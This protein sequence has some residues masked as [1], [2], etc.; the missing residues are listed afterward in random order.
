MIHQPMEPQ[1]NLPRE[2]EDRFGVTL[3][4]E[5]RQSLGPWQV[6]RLD[7]ISQ[8]GFKVAWLPGVNPDRPLRIRIPGLSML[9]AEI[10]WM[11]GRTFGCAFVEPLHIAVFEH[12]LREV[13]KAG[14]LNR[15]PPPKP[16]FDQIWIA[17][18]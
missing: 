11:K 14:K 7:D 15:Q 4:C 16:R 3:F 9:T 5:V 8:A 17:R 13:E 6:A 1:D 10:R 12:I 18:P 2:K